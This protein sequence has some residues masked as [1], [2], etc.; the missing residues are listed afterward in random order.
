[1]STC[2][3][4]LM[5]LPNKLSSNSA[6]FEFSSRVVMTQD[7]AF[8]VIS[9]YL[10][11]IS[12]SSRTFVPDST[13]LSRSF[14]LRVTVQL[15][16][17]SLNCVL[18]FCSTVFMQLSSLSRADCILS[19]C[20]S[21]PVPTLP[22]SFITASAVSRQLTLSGSMVEKKLLFLSVIMLYICTAE[23]MLARL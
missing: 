1:M 16:R 9:L 8:F 4:V 3:I 12:L 15:S 10:P 7:K 17:Y 20:L 23:I 6:S 21:D 11:A 14:P 2:I 19:I 5:S 22:S 13:A 18:A